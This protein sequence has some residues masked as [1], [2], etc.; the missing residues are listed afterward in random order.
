MKVK[1]NN[2]IKILTYSDVLILSGWGL[3]T[4]IFAIFV[5]QQIQGGNLELVGLGQA[6]FLI[7]KSVLQIPIAKF[8]DGIKGEIDDL[9]VMATGS[10]ILSLVPFLYIGARDPFHLLLIQAFYGFGA[11]LVTPGWLAIFTRHVDRDLEA[12]EWSIY[13]SMVGLGAALAG[14][15][16]GFLA[17]KFGF[18]LLFS[19]V[20]T[21][22]VAGTAF[23]YLIYLDLRT[24][25]KGILK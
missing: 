7:L 17:E 14:A 2:L 5:T 11:A 12:E 19:L 8:I 1:V 6:V 18:Q 9:V 3:V 15:L 24:T 23:L 16:G 22:C 25:E 4:P 10:V 20:G 21:T 13:N